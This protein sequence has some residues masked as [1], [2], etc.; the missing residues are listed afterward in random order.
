VSRGPPP[1]E[2]VRD[3][4]V[5]RAGPQPPEHRP[6]VPDPDPDPAQRQPAPNQAGQRGVDL[7]G[8]LRRARP[9]SGHVP[10]Q[11]QRAGPQVQHAQRPSRWRCRVDHVAQSSD[12]LEIQVAGVIEVDVRLRNAVHQQH[13]CRPP[14]GIPQQ[15][16]TA[17]GSV[18][19]VGRRRRGPPPGRSGH[20]ASMVV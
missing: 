20:S 13:P 2:H 9:G 4:H 10:G 1:G 3:H 5:E 11:G 12:V 19:A 8:H 16:G 17:V 14:V 7:D 18:D 6:G 15:L